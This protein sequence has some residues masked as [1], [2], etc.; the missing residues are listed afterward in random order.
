MEIKTLKDLRQRASKI[1]SYID[2]YYDDDIVYGR[3]TLARNLL[4]DLYKSDKTLEEK[5]VLAQYLINKTAYDK[6]KFNL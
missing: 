5:I 3:V 1:L 6:N 2:A 4:S